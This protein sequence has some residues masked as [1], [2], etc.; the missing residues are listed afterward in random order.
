MLEADFNQKNNFIAGWF[1]NEKVCNDL[2]NYFEKS[3]YQPY[4]RAETG[5][6]ISL[7]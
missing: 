1:I 2:I 5:Q 7:R 4:R 6:I 3:S